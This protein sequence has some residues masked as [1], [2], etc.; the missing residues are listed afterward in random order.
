MEPVGSCNRKPTPRSSSNTVC[1]LSFVARVTFAR[2][3][4]QGTLWSGET[5]V[6]SAGSTAP[7]TRTSPAARE[8]TREDE[9]SAI[10]EADR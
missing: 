8:L 5:R 9:V 10:R 4:T 3:H 6:I 1:S 2:Y 7:V